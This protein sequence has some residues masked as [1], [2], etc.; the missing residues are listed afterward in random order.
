MARGKP[1]PETT[2]WIIIRLS[3]TMSVDDIALYT[4]ISPASIRRILKFFKETA[5]VNVPNRCVPT[6]ITKA[7]VTMTLQ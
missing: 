1:I 7:F 4:S 5:D 3:T 2:Q 6:C